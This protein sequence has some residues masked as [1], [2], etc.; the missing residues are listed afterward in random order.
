MSSKTVK[1]TVKDREKAEIF[2]DLRCVDSNLYKKRGNFKREDIVIGALAE[3]AVYKL[4]RKNDI[5][6]GKPDFAIYS[7]GDKS[8]DADLSDSKR[9]F[10]VKGQSVKSAKLYGS[11][12]L[13]QRTDPIICKPESGNYLVPTNVDLSL[14]EVTIF[15][16]Y[17][18]KTIVDKECIGAP[19]LEWLARTKVAIYNDHL[20]G[21]MSESAKWS[22]LYRKVI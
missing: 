4:L 10:H 13:M 17:N 12:W 15:G 9:K 1:L 19:K 6:V 22:M 8:F 14:N 11:S 7:A 21:M 5:K 18:V 20:E 2:A 3:I 16:I